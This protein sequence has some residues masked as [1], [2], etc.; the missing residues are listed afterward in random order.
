MRIPLSNIVFVLCIVTMGASLSLL[1]VLNSHWQVEFL[2]STTL[3]DPFAPALQS[4]PMMVSLC[5]SLL[6]VTKYTV[7]L[8]RLFLNSGRQV[9]G[10]IYHTWDGT[11]TRHWGSR[12][13]LYGD[14]IFFLNSIPRGHRLRGRLLYLVVSIVTRS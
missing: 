5:W 12:V 1:F 9:K 8:P 14:Y 7:L 3:R 10:G 13:W 11:S 4:V 2:N 6:K